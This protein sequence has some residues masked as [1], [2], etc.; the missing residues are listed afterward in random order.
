MA[1]RAGGLKVCSA[2]LRSGISVLNHGYLRL[3]VCMSRQAHQTASRYT[4][5]RADMHACMSVHARTHDCVSPPQRKDCWMKRSECISCAL[6]R[7]CAPRGVVNLCPPRGVVSVCACASACLSVGV[8]V[9]VS[10]GVCRVGSPATP[11]LVTV[12]PPVALTASERSLSSFCEGA[13]KVRED[14]VA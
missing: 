9:G 5:M 1:A 6:R 4:D 3:R 14:Q 7:N 12:A 11:P 13:T 2:C 10:V 8:D